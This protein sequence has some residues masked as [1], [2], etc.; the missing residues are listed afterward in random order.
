MASISS[1]P[2]STLAELKKVRELLD[3]I[4][5]T[6]QETADTEKEVVEAIKEI[7]DK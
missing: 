3:S 5:S 6:N 1:T 4:K 7:T 2:A